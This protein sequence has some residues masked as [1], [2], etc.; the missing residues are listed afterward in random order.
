MN[1]WVCCYWYEPDASTDPVGLVRIWALADVLASVGDDVTVFAPRYRS[2]LVSR[3]SRVVPIPMLP[4]PVIRPISYA[5][6]AFLSGLW[7][8]LRRRPTVVYYRWME[9]LHPLLLARVFGAICICEVN[10]EPVPPWGAA[11][12]RGRLTHA[13]A[14]FALR[15]CDRVVVLTEGLGHLVQAQYG[16]RAD[17]V[18]LLPS[19]SDV[20][21]FYPRE[22][23]RCVQGAGLDPAYEYIGF[24]GS[25]YQYQG[26]GTLLEAF[27][28]LHARRSSV[29]LLLVGDG[30]E[31]AVLRE[32]AAQRGLSRWITWTGRVPYAHVPILIGAM[33]VCVA[34]FCGDRG[35]TSPVKIF[36]YLACGKP[37][38][39]SAIPSVTALFSQSNGVV[40]VEPDR[41][42]LLADAVMAL[43]NRPE[44]SR[45]LGIDGRTF[46]EERFGWEAIVRGLRNL[47]EPTIPPHQHQQRV[48]INNSSERV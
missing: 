23:N 33:D 18:A 32:Q 22:R 44:E 41:A 39:A 12:W 42:E 5:V 38:V 28:R 47:A 35:E 34:P 15:R 43:L 36:D 27:E 37:V 8:G 30:E 19:G 26:L 6:L 45:R 2:A 3:R 46:V 16:V 24:V 31:A 40:L 25:F 48:L 14:S 1:W 13:L 20:S 7:R 29:R 11:G 4:G 17:R 21:L 10:G 9:S